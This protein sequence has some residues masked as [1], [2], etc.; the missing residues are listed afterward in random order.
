MN[1]LKIYNF[2]D[3]RILFKLYINVYKLNYIQKFRKCYYLLN[4]Q[5]FGTQNIFG[6][7]FALNIITLM[8]FHFHICQCPCSENPTYS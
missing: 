1:E 2:S 3:K 7:N 5:Y 6:H 4:S 8:D